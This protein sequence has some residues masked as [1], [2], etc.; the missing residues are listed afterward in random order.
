MLK[1]VVK[2]VA[3]NIGVKSGE[4]TMID[5]VNYLT[6]VEVH[7]QD[8]LENGVVKYLYIR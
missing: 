1:E 2:Y 8:G 7:S 4:K 6:N 5:F 3:K